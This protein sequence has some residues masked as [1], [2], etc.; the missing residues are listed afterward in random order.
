MHSREKLRTVGGVGGYSGNVG[1]AEE[2]A[3]AR[4]LTIP[5]VGKTQIE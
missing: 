2:R 5:T 3:E 1:R 4:A